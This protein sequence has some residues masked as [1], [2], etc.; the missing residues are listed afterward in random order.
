MSLDLVKLEHGVLDDFT[1]TTIKTKIIDRVKELKF[2]DISKYKNDIQFLK[3]V[4]N[5]IEH[6]VEKEDN[7]SKLDFCIEICCQLFCNLTDDEIKILKMNIN[8]LCKNKNVKKVS[9]Y[10]LFKTSFLE[11][12]TKK[13]EK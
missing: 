9:S 8:F 13:P 7:I 4:C 2:E 5:L 6:L 12:F 11:W 3:F 1:K 10:R